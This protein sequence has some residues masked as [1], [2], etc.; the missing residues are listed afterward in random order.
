MFSQNVLALFLLLLLLAVIGTIQAFR[1][2][3]VGIRGRL[4]CG[5]KPLS[6]AK[7]K[8]WNKNKLGASL[9]KKSLPNGNFFLKKIFFWHF[10]N[11]TAKT[12]EL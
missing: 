7:V 3:S 10:F 11:G 9:F 2:Q 12:H 8:L 6:G 1:Q 5:D 4:F